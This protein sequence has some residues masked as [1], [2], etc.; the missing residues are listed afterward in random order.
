MTD[1]Q[2]TLA[3]FLGTYAATGVTLFAAMFL[4]HKGRVKAHIG[5][6]LVFLALFGVTI[7]FADQTGHV[8]ELDARWKAIHLPLAYLATGATLL[9]LATGFLHWRGKTGLFLHKVGIALFLLPFV[10]ASVTGGIMLASSTA[11]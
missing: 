2:R 8:Y 11:K 3:L 10:A 9:P 5:A 1:S 7:Y 4:G 6:I